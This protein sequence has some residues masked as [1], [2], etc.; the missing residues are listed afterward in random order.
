MAEY[1]LGAP[2]ILI[3]DPTEAAGAGMFDV[4]QVPQAIIRI[5]TSK[6]RARDVGGLPRAEGAFDRGTRAQVEIQLYDAQA[7]ILANLLSN[8]SEGADGGIEFSTNYQRQANVPTLCVIPN[9]FED[10][11][12]SNA[13]VWWVPA[14]DVEGQIELNYNDTEGNEANQPYTVTFEALLRETDQDGNAIPAGRRII[15][16]GEAEDGWSLPAPYGST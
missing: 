10:D 4:G 9:G 8:A 11:A 1:P 13:G 16:R 15:F 7:E 12:A 6:A 2:S 14:A 5:S 3:G